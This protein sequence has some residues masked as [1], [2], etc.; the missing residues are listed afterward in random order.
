M[1]N[2]A[3]KGPLMIEML[4]LRG[5]EQED[6]KSWMPAAAYMFPLG[7]PLVDV[8]PRWLLGRP[9]LRSELWTLAPAM[10]ELLLVGRAL[11]V[12]HLGL[13][14]RPELRSEPG[15]L[16]AAAALPLLRVDAGASTE[17]GDPAGQ[18]I[19]SSMEILRGKDL[20]QPCRG[21]GFLLERPGER[22]LCPSPVIC[23]VLGR[24]EGEV[25][26]TSPTDRCALGP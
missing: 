18:N 12:C 21:G 19:S 15:L 14:K 25:L 24:R 26:C 3:T 8:C 2:S 23:C 4:L 20:S 5:D 13:V 10:C 11:T 17:S 6:E 16:V 1:L 22:G 9:E 7:P